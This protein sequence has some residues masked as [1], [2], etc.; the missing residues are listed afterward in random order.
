M[1]LILNPT[2]LGIG[3]AQNSTKRFKEYYNGKKTNI[4]LYNL[5]KKHARS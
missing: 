1:S 3:S 5:V 2:K 4:H